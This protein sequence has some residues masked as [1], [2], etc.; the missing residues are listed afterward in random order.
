V[1][2]LEELDPALIVQ[3]FAD[4]C[5]DSPDFPD[6]TSLD[7]GVMDNFAKKKKAA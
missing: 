5:V 3:V 2:I 7:R 6:R 1:L 4:P